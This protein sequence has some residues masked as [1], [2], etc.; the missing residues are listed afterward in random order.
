MFPSFL[1]PFFLKLGFHV[2]RVAKEHSI[3][4]IFLLGKKQT[5]NRETSKVLRRL[6]KAPD[7]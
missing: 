6:R 7:L 3:D 4:R 5:V 1:P 2:K